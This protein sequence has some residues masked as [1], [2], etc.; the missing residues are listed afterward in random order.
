LKIITIGSQAFISGFML[1]GASGIHVTN[2]SDALKQINL[3]LNTKDVGLVLVSSEISKEIEDELNDIRS[4]NPTPLIYSI[5]GPG[6]NIE[7]VNYRD[8]IKK[9]LKMS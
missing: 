1:S 7:Q 5:P 3:L 8:L 2:P 9:V 6:S 4:N